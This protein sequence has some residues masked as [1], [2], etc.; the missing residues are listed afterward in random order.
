M[1]RFALSHP[2]M[3]RFLSSGLKQKLN[4]FKPR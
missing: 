2:Q 1:V 4:L 3:D